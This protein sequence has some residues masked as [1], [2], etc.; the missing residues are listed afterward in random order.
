MT[1]TPSRLSINDGPAVENAATVV[2]IFAGDFLLT[3]KNG[4][5][6]TFDEMTGYLVKIED[7]LQKL[8]S[9]IVFDPQF[10]SIISRQRGFH[11]NVSR[12]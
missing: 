12:A 2:V 10:K 6:Y 11:L 1:A 5:R 7:T 3:T 9:P 4:Y 8:P